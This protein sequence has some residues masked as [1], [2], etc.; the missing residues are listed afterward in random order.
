VLGNKFGD[1]WDRLFPIRSRM[2]FILFERV[3]IAMAMAVIDYRITLLARFIVCRQ[4]DPIMPRPTKNFRLEG[5][6]EIGR[7]RSC[8]GCNKNNRHKKQREHEIYRGN[9]TEL[10]QTHEKTTRGLRGGCDEMDIQI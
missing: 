9:I 1:F 10:E 6:I 4:E 8:R 3:P 5:L 2:D 7:A